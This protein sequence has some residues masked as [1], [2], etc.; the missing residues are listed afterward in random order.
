MKEEYVNIKTRLYIPRVI[1]D[2]LEAKYE[3]L[4]HGVSATL[5][6]ALYKDNKQNN[7]KTKIGIINRSF[8]TFRL[9]NKTKYTKAELRGHLLQDRTF[10]KLFEKYEKSDFKRKKMPSL[11]LHKNLSGV[12]VVTYGERIAINNAARSKPVAVVT[13]GNAIL[14]SS[15]SDC[16]RKLNVDINIIRARLAKY[17]KFGEGRILTYD[18]YETFLDK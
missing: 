8:A 7:G 16:A 15:I 11:I 5:I 18:E 3:T 13:R 1:Q 9:K 10:L 4:G 14:Y 6:T 2:E 17:P 12:K